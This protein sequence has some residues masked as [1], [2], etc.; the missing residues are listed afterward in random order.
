M[1]KAKQ[2]S[3]TRKLHNRRSKWD[4]VDC[5]TN[6]SYEHYFAKNE[7]WIGEAGMSE[8]GMLCIGCLETRI[9]RRLTP[10]DFTDAHI[11]NPKTHP[12]TERLLSRLR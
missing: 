11:N 9:G 4:C 12:M 10:D 5:D 2:K 3:I 6:T 8:T 7:V 1:S